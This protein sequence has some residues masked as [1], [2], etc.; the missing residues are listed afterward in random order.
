ML[1]PRDTRK[2]V[3]EFANIALPLRTPGRA[4]FGMRP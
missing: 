3:C 4:A 2:M 1:D